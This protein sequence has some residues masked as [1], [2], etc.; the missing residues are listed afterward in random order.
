MIYVA[1]LRGINVGGNSIIAMSQ[2]KEVFEKLG[3]ADVRTYINSGNVIFSTDTPHAK[4]AATIEHSIEKALAMPITVVVRSLPEMKA[5]AAVV[6]ASWVNDAEQKTDVLFL[7]DQI[8][9]KD[10]LSQFKLKPEIDN[11]KYVH[12]AVVWNVL[13]K[14]IGRSG[15]LKIV[16]TPLYKQVS[17]RNVNTLRKLVALMQ[18]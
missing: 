14:D 16:G 2:L 13:R 17:I 9:T 1:L 8:N 4:L 5:I 12:G 11:V 10:V 3:F 6:P 7:W 18:S 15:L